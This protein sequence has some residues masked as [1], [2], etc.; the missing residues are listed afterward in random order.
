MA[1][2]SPESSRNSAPLVASARDCSEISS[3]MDRI[4]KKITDAG[5]DDKLSLKTVSELLSEAKERAEK[6][7]LGEYDFAREEEDD[8]AVEEVPEELRETEEDK[9]LD[10]KE[11]EQNKKIDRVIGI[12]SG[13]VISATFAYIAYRFIST[14]FL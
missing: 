13:I 7:K 12:I 3:A 8:A 6:I 2:I 14:W 10:E 11:R 1:V 5:V 4:T 9:I